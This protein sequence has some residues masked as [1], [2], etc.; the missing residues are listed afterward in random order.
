[1]SER[2]RC[3]TEVIAMLTSMNDDDSG[4]K[5]ETE[6][7]EVLDWELCSSN[8]ISDDE[9]TEQFNDAQ[10][11]VY[12]GDLQTADSNVETNSA[13]CFDDDSGSSTH[14]TATDSTKWKFMEF[15]VET[16]ERRAV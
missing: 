6:E 10:P 12:V 2:P 4:R 5:S 9:E 7:D 16:Q 1:M 11:I 3:F 14:E 8:K 15:G 13:T